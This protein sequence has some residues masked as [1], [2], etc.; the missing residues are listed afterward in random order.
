MFSLDA[1]IKDGYLDIA[2]LFGLDRSEL[3]YLNINRDEFNQALQFFYTDPYAAPFLDLI[4]HTVLYDRVASL[5]QHFKQNNGLL[6]LKWFD[7]WFNEFETM[8][9]NG[10]L[11]QELLDQLMND[12]GLGDASDWDDIVPEPPVLEPQPP[13]EQVPV[14]SELSDHQINQLLELYIGFFGRAVESSGLEHHKNNLLQMLQAGVSEEEAFNSIAT[15]FWGAALHYNTVTGYDASMSNFDFVAKV[16][17]NV[18]GR[19]D[20]VE[21]DLDGIHFWVDVMDQGHSQGE[22]VLAILDVAHLYIEQNPTDSVSLY[23]N[24]LLDNRTE[25]SLFFA[26]EAVS[27]HLL[28]ADAINLGVDVLNR[29]DH[30]PDSV[31]RVKDAL[32]N[33][34]LHELPEI[35]LIGIPDL[36]LI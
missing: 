24:N 13:V 23:V 27:G 9:L 4:D 18:L 6:E 12:L 22:M 32:L 7:N 10:G 33:N 2:G 20:A 15:E 25:I 17:A 19:P 30:T 35:E 28:D 3:A 11:D 34:T 1:Y 26:Q 36:S 31:A 21:N 5:L 29:I 14:I 16:Y 8:L